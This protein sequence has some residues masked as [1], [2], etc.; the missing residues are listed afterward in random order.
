MFTTVGHIVHPG[1]LLFNYIRSEHTRPKSVNRTTQRIAEYC[2]LN[3]NSVI[4]N[5]NNRNKAHILTHSFAIRTM[6]LSNWQCQFTTDSHF[7]SLWIFPLLVRFMHTHASLKII[8][9]LAIMDYNQR[10]SRIGIHN[11]SLETY[12]D[13]HSS[14]IEG[15]L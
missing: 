15:W 10:A 4:F 7:A 3:F 2:N 11:R 8:F 13:I 5:A 14:S 6:L 1:T 9:N 12:K